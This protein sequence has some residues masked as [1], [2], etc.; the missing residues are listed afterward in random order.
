MKLVFYSIVLNHHQVYVADEFYRILG[1]NYAFV[2]LTKCNQNKGAQNDFSQRP[3]LIRAWKSTD[4]YNMAMQL[5]KTAEVCVFSGYEA[6]P[7]QKVRMN[8]GLL[9]F[10]MSERWLK[11]GLIN[12]VSPRIL[13]MFF[14][15]HI[16]GWKNKPIY[17]LCCSAFAKLDMNLLGMYKEKCYK[18]G[19]FTNVDANLN[20]QSKK[21]NFSSS[22]S[23]SF[24]WCARFLKWKHP[25]LPIYLASKLMEKGYKFTLDMYGA[26]VELENTKKLARNLAVEDV[27]SFKGNVPNDQIIQAMCT[28]DI[29]LFTS[30][31]NEG[32]GAVAN[33]AMSN[34]CCFVGSNKIGSVPYLVEEG[35]NGLIFESC[36]IES[37]TDKV[38]YLMDHPDKLYQLAEAGVF[39][40][41]NVWSPEC[42][43]KNLLKLIMS[44]Q[45][46]QSIN[47]VQ[48]PCSIA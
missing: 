21:Q 32:W 28:H 5:A 29:F 18:W 35:D 34:G 10:D 14:A 1:E 17:K 47:I 8:L 2:E 20:I 45:N 33:E 44:L 11:K 36:D 38:M 3:Y 22:K 25:E 26:G 46:G 31:S 6:L 24:M 12:L 7:F 40:M 23:I 48:G 37:L 42:A 41:Q 30:D 15:Y 4:D 16:G 39:T 9:S 13:K 43:A 27:V 19:Y